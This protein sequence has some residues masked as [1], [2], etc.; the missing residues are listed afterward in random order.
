MILA[1]LSARLSSRTITLS[2]FTGANIYEY[3]TTPSTIEAQNAPTLSALAIVVATT[4]SIAPPRPSRHPSPPLPSPQTSSACSAALSPRVSTQP[5]RN[6]GCLCRSWPR[7]CNRRLPTYCFHARRSHKLPNSRP[8]CRLRAPSPRCYRHGQPHANPGGFEAE[9]PVPLAEAKS[10]R[11][12]MY[13]FGH[14]IY[15]TV[16]PRARFVKEILSGFDLSKFKDVG[17]SRRKLSGARARMSGFAVGES[18]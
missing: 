14:C 18:G 15:E 16:D 10:G 12:K 2:A 9:V 17:R 7:Q 3:N 5:S 4:Y 11:Q 1:C 6:F 8:E 13:G